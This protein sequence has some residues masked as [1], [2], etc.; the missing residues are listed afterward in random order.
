M[1]AAL[2]PTQLLDWTPTRN[3]EREARRRFPG[4]WFIDNTQPAQTVHGNLCRLIF[5]QGRPSDSRWVW[6]SALVLP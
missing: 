6:A 3:S 5:P 4:I 2:R 1:D